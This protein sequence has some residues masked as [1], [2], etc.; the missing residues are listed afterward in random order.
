MEITRGIIC[1]NIIALIQRNTFAELKK[2]YQT[3]KKS[4][5]IVARNLTKVIDPK[6]TVFF[7]LPPDNIF[8]KTLLKLLISK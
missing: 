1:Y 5:A 8:L 3:L 7:F 2:C 6:Q 4:N